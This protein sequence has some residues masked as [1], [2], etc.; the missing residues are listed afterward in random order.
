MWGPLYFFNFQGGK[1]PFLPPPPCG[2][3]WQGGVANMDARRGGGGARVG[4]RHTIESHEKK[5]SLHVGPFR[6]FFSLWEPF[7][8]VFLLTGS[9]F[10]IWSLSATFF[11]YLVVLFCLY[12]GL[13]WAYPPPPLSKFLRASMGAKGI[14]TLPPYFWRGVQPPLIFFYC[15]H[16]LCTYYF[17]KVG[18][19]GG[20]VSN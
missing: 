14:A 12:G 20:V 6:Y 13:F 18:G 11:L 3:P 2:R 19:G 15:L 16:M 17:Y 7:C 9:I 5:F 4:R 10:I 1:C 8:Y